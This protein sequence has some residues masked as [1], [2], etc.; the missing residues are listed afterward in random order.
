M[1]IHHNRIKEFWKVVNFIHFTS[2]TTKY[3][4]FNTRLADTF[5]WKCIF[6]RENLFAANAN[7]KIDISYATSH[8]KTKLYISMWAM[9]A[10]KDSYLKNN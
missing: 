1:R 7:N 6:E 8:D 9:D 3:D 10:Y 5:S 2:E 4:V